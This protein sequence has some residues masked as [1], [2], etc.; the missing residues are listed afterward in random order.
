MGEKRILEIK[1]TYKVS[2]KEN[3]LVNT[4]SLTLSDFYL[5]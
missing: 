3:C 1:K 2:N 5:N 4:P